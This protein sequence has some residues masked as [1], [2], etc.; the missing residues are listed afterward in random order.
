VFHGSVNQEK[1]KRRR[2]KIMPEKKYS[3]K[4]MPSDPELRSQV[5]EL[6]EKAQTDESYIMG[7]RALALRFERWANQCKNLAEI[8][9]QAK[10]YF[11]PGQS[12]NN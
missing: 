5:E 2:V 10:Q 6:M 7:L 9:E 3:K 8:T 12:H 1:E 11:E 4:D